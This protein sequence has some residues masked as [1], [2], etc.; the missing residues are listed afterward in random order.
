MTKHGRR[1]VSAGMQ[2]AGL[3]PQGHSLLSP[4]W[5]ANRFA[6]RLAEFPKMV[7]TSPESASLSRLCS[8]PLFMG[9]FRTFPRTFVISRWGWGCGHR[10][11]LYPGNPSV[12]TNPVALSKG[13]GISPNVEILGPDA[14]CQSST[15]AILSGQAIANRSPPSN[16]KMLPP[17][18]SVFRSL[19]STPERKPVDRFRSYSVSE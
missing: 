4:G 16:K 19:K 17:G 11:R 5:R 2:P 7:S 18:I 8:F 6:Q 13:C 15:P 14:S 9:P 1:T 3:L 10:Q 12:P